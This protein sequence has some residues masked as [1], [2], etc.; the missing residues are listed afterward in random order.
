LALALSARAGLQ[1]ED[2]QLPPAMMQLERAAAIFAH[3]MAQDAPDHRHRLELARTHLRMADAQHFNG[4]S[5]G[6]QLQTEQAREVLNS[7]AALAPG[8][9]ELPHVWVWVHNR[10]VVLAQARG[11]WLTVVEEESTSRGRLLA[12]AAKAPDNARFQEDLASAEQWL[13]VAAGE[14]NQPAQVQRWSDEALG[15]WASLVK[16]DPLDRNSNGKRLESLIHACVAFRRVAQREVARQHCAAA[17]AT[18]LDMAQRWPDET[19]LPR[20]RVA[21][22][23]AQAALAKAE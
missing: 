15:R 7:L 1:A 13:M 21:L 17:Q 9:K 6:S 16:R 18:L 5:A 11:D 3:R 23:A 19:Y 14:M 10:A 12:L 4:D 8:H 22:N 20:R 2:K